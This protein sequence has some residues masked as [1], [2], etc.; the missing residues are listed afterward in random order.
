[1]D[2]MGNILIKRLSKSPVYARNTLEVNI[3]CWNSY[4]FLTS[5]CFELKLSFDSG[6][7]PLQ[8]HHQAVR[9]AAG[10][11]QAVQVVWHEEVPAEREQGA[12]EAVPGQKEVG[13]SVHK[14]RLLWHQQFGHPWLSHL[15]EQINSQREICCLPTKSNNIPKVLMV[16]VVAMEMLRTKIPPSKCSLVSDVVGKGKQFPKYCSKRQEVVFGVESC[17][18]KMCFPKL[19]F[20]KKLH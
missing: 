3:C 4:D 14:P 5:H 2:D 19:L 1:M 10:A 7:R 15:G 11:G 18:A 13:E 20:S 6:V 16:N 8:R 9:G 17:E 12:E